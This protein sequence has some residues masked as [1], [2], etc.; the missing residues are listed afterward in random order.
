M[1]MFGEEKENRLVDKCLLAELVEDIQK[2][3]VLVN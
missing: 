2:S 1:V 3:M